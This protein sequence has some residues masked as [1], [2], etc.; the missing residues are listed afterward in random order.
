MA[1]RIL[2]LVV[3][4]LQTCYLTVLKSY[5]HVLYGTYECYIPSTIVYIYWTE[6]IEL[7]YYT[8]PIMWIFFVLFC[9][10]DMLSTLLGFFVCYDI[11]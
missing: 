10:K 1:L 11:V 6:L 7:G 5:N 9:L 3:I 4:E 8:T 2:I